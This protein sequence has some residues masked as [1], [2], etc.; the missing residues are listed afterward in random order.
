MLVMIM[1]LFIAV[2][3]VQAKD[4][5]NIPQAVVLSLN[6]KY[7]GAIVKKWT[8]KNNAYTAK[9]MINGHK[10][11]ASFDGQGNWISTASNTNFVYK[12]PKVI[13]SAYLKT[14]YNNWTVYFAKEVE[15]P[16]GKYYQVLVDDVNLHTGI[17]HQMVYTQE[18]MLEFKADGM[19]TNIKD[20]TFNPEP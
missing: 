19:L 11:Y 14:P 8:M 6:T 13:N 3:V 9:A 2:E 1:G 15:K 16:S 7:P 12:M 17:N 4:V 18:K 5:T 10:Y 20:I